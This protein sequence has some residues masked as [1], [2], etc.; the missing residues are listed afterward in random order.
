MAP[1]MHVNEVRMVEATLWNPP[2]GAACHAKLRVLQHFFLVG[3]LLK[4]ICFLSSNFVACL[5][6]YCDKRS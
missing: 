4:I 5:D 1:P 3:C 6:C 2:A